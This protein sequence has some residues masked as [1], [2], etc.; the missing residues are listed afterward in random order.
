MNDKEEHAIQ[1]LK[2]YYN[3]MEKSFPKEETQMTTEHKKKCST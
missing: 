2:N 1:Y 3:N